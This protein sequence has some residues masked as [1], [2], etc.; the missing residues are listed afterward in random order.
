MKLKIDKTKCIGCGTCE[1]LASK[2]FKVGEDGKG[3]VLPEPH[4]DEE[5]IKQA[6]ESCP[7]GA[8]EIE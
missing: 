7:L 1:I 8:I 6:I 4:D 5:M 3:T 2:T